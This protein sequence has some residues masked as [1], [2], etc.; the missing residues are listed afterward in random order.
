MG[1]SCDLSATPAPEQSACPGTRLALSEKDQLKKG[2]DEYFAVP[3]LDRLA[4]ISAR[5]CAGTQ[6]FVQV[7][8]SLKDCKK[9]CNCPEG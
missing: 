2:H 9:C 3:I 5:S 7:L 6:D 4:S 8:V 1:V